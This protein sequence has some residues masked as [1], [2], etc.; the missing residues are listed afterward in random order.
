MDRAFVLL[1][2][3]AGDI[4]DQCF[5]DKSVYTHTGR[6]GGLN[7]LLS[8]AFWNCYFDSVIGFL[9][10]AF[11]RFNLRLCHSVVTSFCRILYNTG[12]ILSRG[13]QKK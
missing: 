11:V 9:S 2:G 1:F 5:F 13:G 12:I 8:V 7:D 3:C 10:E 6:A 4:F